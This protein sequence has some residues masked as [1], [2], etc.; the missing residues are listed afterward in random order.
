VANPAMCRN[1]PFALS[2][3][4]ISVIGGSVVDLLQVAE[5][6]AAVVPYGL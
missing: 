1:V 3:P 4:K 5:S 2:S 6:I